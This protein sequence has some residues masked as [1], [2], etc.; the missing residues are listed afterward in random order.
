MAVADLE[1]VLRRAC[2]ARRARSIGDD[3]LDDVPGLA[4]VAAGVHRERAADRARNAGEELRAGQVVLAA[5]R[6]TF[7][8]ATPASA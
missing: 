5:K 7:G 8:L 4:A 6:A 3:A 2:A 1:F